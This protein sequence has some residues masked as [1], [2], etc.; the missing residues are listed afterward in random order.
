MVTILNYTV[1]ELSVDLILLEELYSSNEFRA[2]FLNN[3][4]GQTKKIGRLLRLEHSSVELER[5]SDII[6]SLESDEGDIMILIE[7]KIDAQFQPHQA[8]DYKKR[9]LGYIQRGECADCITVLLAPNSY[10]SK[11]KGYYKFDFYINFYS[12]VTYVYLTHTLTYAFLN[13]RDSK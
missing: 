2:W 8:E 11:V 12:N 10:I 7:N 13:Y 1:R 3:T 6:L 4:Y 9:A 5:E